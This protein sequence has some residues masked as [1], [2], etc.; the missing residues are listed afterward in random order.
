MVTSLAAAASIAALSAPL[1]DLYEAGKDKFKD[2]LSRWNNARQ[3]K[4]IAT[5]VA[6]YEQVKTIWQREKKVKLSAF[7]YPSKVRLPTG[8]TK[9]VI[10]LRDLPSSGGVVLQGTVGQ[11]KTVFLRYLCIQELSTQASGRIPVFFELRKLDSGLNLEKALFNTLESLGFE[12]TD[13]LFDYYAE[14]GKLVILLDGFDEIEESLVRDVITRIEAWAIRYP[15]MQLFITCRPGGEIQK[16]NHFSTIQLA[17]LTPEE[18]RPFMIKIGVK[19]EILDQLLVAIE[20]SPV[21]I[22]GLLTTPLLLTLLVLVY[23]SEGVIPNE[24]P[25]FFKLL[26]ATVFSRHDHSKPAFRR[27]HKSGLN[28]RKLEH[29]FEAFCFAVMRRK[30]TVNLKDDQFDTAFLDASTFSDEKCSLDGFRHDIVKVACLLQED[31]LFISFVHKSLLDYF[32]A[33]FIK[34]CT[35]EQATRIY[36]SIASHWRQWQ[37]VLHFLSYIDKY[38]FA[39]YFAIPQLQQI[40]SE[41]SVHDGKVTEKSIN[42][43]LNWTFTPETKFRFVVDPK[44]NEYVQ[45]GFGPWINWD[46]FFE[47]HMALGHIVDPHDLVKSQKLKCKYETTIENDE[48]C[49]LVHWKDLLTPQQLE[50]VKQKAR[51]YLVRLADQLGSYQNLVADEIR[52]ASLFA[53]LDVST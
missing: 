8:I 49:Y 12:V 41:F 29:F 5:K 30:Y 18:H 40:V 7:Y 19:G 28:E 10:S 45:R 47:D 11:G 17:P 1:K 4:A 14:S 22:R 26:F 44:T 38:R 2:Q 33:A 43:F 13:E 24:L 3:L 27:A 15:Q 51:T 23:Q 32:P 42:A 46:S 52:K 9:T 6:A 36:E 53:A 16:S 48:T 35:D 39:R 20:K 31:G 21:E 50:E 25:E 34:N 37:H